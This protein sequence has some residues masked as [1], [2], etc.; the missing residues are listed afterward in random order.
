[1]K[2]CALRYGIV[3]GEREWYGRVLTEF[4]KR[5]V[6][7]NK[8]PVIFGDGKQRRDY[9]YVKDV[10]DFH[11]LMIEEEW[12]GFE[13]FNIGSGNSITIKELAYLIIDIT[14]KD[15]EPIFED[16]PEGSYSNITGRWRIPKE[17]KILELN[18]SKAMKK[19]WKPRTS[20][21]EGI[22]KKLIGYTQIQ[23]DGI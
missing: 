10:V 5:V 7:E 14:N 17:L 22:K 1:M 3:Y 21:R 23:I 15:M 19:G 18:I 16:I 4:I 12:D 20:L 11:N 9:I 13:V 8:P 2:I 6:L